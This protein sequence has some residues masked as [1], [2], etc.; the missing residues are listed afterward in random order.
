MTR[1]WK[2]HRPLMASVNS[3]SLCLSLLDGPLEIHKGLELRTP[4]KSLEGGLRNSTDPTTLF[5]MYEDAVE[6]TKHRP[7]ST[8][9]TFM[10][11]SFIILT[12]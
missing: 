10:V 6:L 2:T 11:P 1:V 8:R 12:T 9:P 4:G 7:V 5:P 3:G